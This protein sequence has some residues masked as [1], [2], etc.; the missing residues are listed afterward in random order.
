M[1]N[2]QTNNTHWT[3]HIFHVYFVDAN[4]QQKHKSIVLS[5]KYPDD[6]N[7]L[8]AQTE[9]GQEK[10][11]KKRERVKCE[12]KKKWMAPNNIKLTIANYKCWKH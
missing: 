10:I 9:K 11:E 1:N 3:F 2:G 4:Q 7:Y 12:L 6:C 5:T 8:K